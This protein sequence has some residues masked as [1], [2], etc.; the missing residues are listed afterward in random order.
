MGKIQAVAG[1]VTYTQKKYRFRLYG[2]NCIIVGENGAG[3]TSLLTDIHSRVESQIERGTAAHDIGYREGIR[4]QIMYMNRDPSLEHNYQSGI[5]SNRDGLRRNIGNCLVKIS[6]PLEMIEDF[7]KH[8]AI[9]KFF[10]ASRKSEIREVK[11]ASAVHKDTKGIYGSYNYGHDLE[12]HLVNMQVRAALSSHHDKNDDAFNKI[13][14]WM[15]EFNESL[16]YLF[17]D[18]SVEAIFNPDE[19]RYYIHQNGKL[20]FGFQSLS[21]GYSAI[22]GIFSDLLIRTEYYNVIPTELSGIVLIDEIDAHLHISLQRKILPFFFKSFPEVQ[23]IVT[24][25]SPFVITSTDDSVIYDIS[26]SRVSHDLSMYSLEAIVEGLLG[27]PAISKSL[28]DKIKRLL[29]LTSM[30]SIPQEAVQIAKEISPY[31]DSM[32]SESRMHFEL[33]LNKILKHKINGN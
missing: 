27:V 31:R 33:A 17:E 13:N 19:L 5:K 7:K 16:K 11:D 30:A 8:K 32:D 2:K 10:A 18:D 24:T 21:S 23:F 9:V 22:F 1:R 15:K 3:K 29:E 20:P 28:E 14:S 12:Q 4:S 6:R 26:K 25:H